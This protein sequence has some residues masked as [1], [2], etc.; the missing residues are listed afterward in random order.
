MEDSSVAND[1][2]FDEAGKL[3]DELKNLPVMDEE[4]WIEEEEVVQKAVSK[5]PKPQEVGSAH[6]R[7]ASMPKEDSDKEDKLMD[8]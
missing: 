5:K 2:N 8:E 1:Q 6:K 7:P 3:T 4:G